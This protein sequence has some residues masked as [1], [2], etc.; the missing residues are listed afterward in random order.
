MQSF[1]QTTM[2]TM[3]VI[4]FVL[5][6]LSIGNSARNTVVAQASSSDDVAIVW[7]EEPPPPPVKR[8]SRS[9]PESKRDWLWFKNPSPIGTP[10]L[11]TNKPTPHPLRTD[12]WK[13][14]LHWRTARRK[15]H[16]RDET[17]TLDFDRDGYVRATRTNDSN[18][19]SAWIGSWELLSSGLFWKLCLDDSGTEH[20]FHADLHLNPFGRQPKLTKGIVI[21]ERSS[22]SK[23]FR[24]VTATFTGL[25]V[26]VDTVDLTYKTSRRQR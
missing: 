26:G 15:N 17:L 25:G 2:A 4:V 11:L 10:Q 1:M 5:L 22:R 13:V 9:L 19:S 21:Q 16:E 14:D 23:W 24:P 18:S 3:T 12:I 6:L 20:Y 7:E 8:V